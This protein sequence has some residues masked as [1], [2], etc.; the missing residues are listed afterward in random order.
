VSRTRLTDE[1]RTD[2]AGT[3]V[4]GKSSWGRR[5]RGGLREVGETARPRGSAGAGG[6]GAAAGS[7][8]AGGDGAAAGVRGSW[9]RQR[10]YGV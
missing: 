1:A 2:E 10:D 8:G 5:D 9:G 6:D 7:E 3:A 4:H